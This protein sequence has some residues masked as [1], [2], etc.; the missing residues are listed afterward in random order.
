VSSS[1]VLADRQ[2]MAYS[3]CLVSTGSG[4][5]V[6]VAT[7]QATELGRISHLLQQV[8]VLQTPLLRD[9]ARFARQ[10]SL[11]ILVLAAA[12]LTFGFLLRDYSSAELL[13]ARVRLAVAAIPEGL[14]AV[15]TIILALGV[16]RMARERAISCRLPAVESL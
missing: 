2:S 13:V 3:G 7:G 15:L 14:R 6:V 12:T 16:Q 5:G 8:E 9:M 1:A 10:L 11:V 4:Y